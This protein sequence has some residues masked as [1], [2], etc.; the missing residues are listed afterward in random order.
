MRSHNKIGME[1]MNLVS[2]VL[3]CYNCK[4]LCKQRWNLK[5]HMIL[6]HT[7]V[8]WELELTSELACL[9]I[10]YGFNKDWR[11][12]SSWFRSNSRSMG[13]SALHGR[14]SHPLVRDLA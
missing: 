6:K 3:P 9:T 13:D 8:A 1:K 5:G 10:S 11:G 14:T 7:K 2:S 12:S 4:K